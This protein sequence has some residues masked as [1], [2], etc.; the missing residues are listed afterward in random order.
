[1][2]NNLK[3]LFLILITSIVFTGCYTVAWQPGEALPTKDNLEQIQTSFY[4]VNDFGVFSDY[5][6]SAW[7]VNPDYDF[8]RNNLTAKNDL[9]DNNEVSDGI[10]SGVD[11]GIIILNP[12]PIA[13]PAIILPSPIK[14]HNTTTVKDGNPTRK[15]RQDRNKIRNNNGGR[16][17]TKGRQR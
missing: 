15:V 16:K 17:T 4:N 1:M 2:S 8:L 11:I 10:L 13:P 14:L 12:L 5:Y 9:D 3:S 6:N 7:W